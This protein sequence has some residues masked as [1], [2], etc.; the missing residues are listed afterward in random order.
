MLLVMSAVETDPW[1]PLVLG[2]IHSIHDGFSHL[3][4]LDGGGLSSLYYPTNY[5]KDKGTSENDILE[6]GIEKSSNELPLPCNYFDLIIID[7]STGGYVV[8]VNAD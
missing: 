1:S 4:T 6:N 5:E 7:T 2:Y 8:Y 3:T